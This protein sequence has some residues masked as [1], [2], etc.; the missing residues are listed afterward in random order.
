[1]KCPVCSSP[2]VYPYKEVEKVQ[3]YQCRKCLLAFVDPKTPRKNTSHI[4][5]FADYQKREEQFKKRYTKTLRL[6]N[7]YTK[8]KHILEV[9]AG[10]GLLS[11]MMAKN[12]YEVDALEPTVTPTYLKDLPVHVL[13]K[14][15]ETF[16]KTTTKKYDGIVLYD[17]FEHVNT[18]KDIVVLF[19]KLLNKNGIVLIQTPNY[20]SMM[21]RIVKNWSWWMVEDHRFFYSKKSLSLIFPKKMWKECYFCTYEDWYDFKKNL[22]GNFGIHKFSKYA[23]FSWWIPYYFLL[24][25]L[26]WKFGK[27]GLI[28]T[29]YQKK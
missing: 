21:A 12:G 1:M 14:S 13:K 5:T 18:P 26:L 7:R 27:G 9:G 4:Y 29:I 20:L 10:F 8:G 17:V 22:D 23:F 16:A 11:S 6:L 3:I 19:K 2:H 24:R 28:L 15:F 25:Q